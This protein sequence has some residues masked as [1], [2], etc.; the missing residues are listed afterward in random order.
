MKAFVSNLIARLAGNRPAARKPIRLGVEGLE[1]RDCPTTVQAVAVYAATMYSQLK[2]D[3]NQFAVHTALVET[4]ATTPTLLNILDNNLLSQDANKVYG[5]TYNNASPSQLFTDLKGFV[6]DVVWEAALTQQYGLPGQFALLN[7]SFI[8]SDLS[9]IGHDI[10]QLDGL[11]NWVAANEQSATLPS[12]NPYD[13]STQFVQNQ[14]ASVGLAGY[15][16]TSPEF[17]ALTGPPPVSYLFMDNTP[18]QGPGNYT[19]AQYGGWN[20]TP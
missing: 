3:V 4:Y 14:L 20:F 6:H 10:G 13:F 5:D 12:S 11:A 1:A 7:Y 2:A 16:A 17:E 15:S 19:T 8:Q 18:V 9:A